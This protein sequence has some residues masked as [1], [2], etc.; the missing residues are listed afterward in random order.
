MKE[1]CPVCDNM[2][3][4][5]GV[6]VNNNTEDGYGEMAVYHDCPHCHAELKIIYDAQAGYGFK[7]IEKA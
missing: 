3:D 5:D 6:D 2:I 1:K 7:R 4:L